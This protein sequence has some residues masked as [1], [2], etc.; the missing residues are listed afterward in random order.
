MNIR[1]SNYSDSRRKALTPYAIQKPAFELQ[2][3]ES[4]LGTRLT[5]REDLMGAVEGTRQLQTVDAR[6]LCRTES[7][8]KIQ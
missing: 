2:F 4:G 6:F 8:V 3:P 5:E 1:M 7:E